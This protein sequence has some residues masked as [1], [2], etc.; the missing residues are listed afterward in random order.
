MK[1]LKFKTVVG[2]VAIA[3]A[4]LTIPFV[5]TS[6]DSN[7]P[8]V[9]KEVKTV[10]VNLNYVKDDPDFFRTVLETVAEGSVIEFVDATVVSK[11]MIKE[12]VSFIV[13]KMISKKLTVKDGTV[14]WMRPDLIDLLSQTDINNL[15]RL[16]IRLMNS[17]TAVL[18]PVADGL[19]I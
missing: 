1:E 4:T 6:C 19:I 13:N 18:V 8:D 5:S 14:I 3:A 17:G 12:D 16:G 11:G 7:K 15:A 2:T 10:K 9:T